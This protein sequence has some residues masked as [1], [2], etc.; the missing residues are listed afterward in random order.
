[1][2]LVTPTQSL[3]FPA[4]DYIREVII[5]TCITKHSTAMVIIDGTHIHYIDSTMAKVL[6]HILTLFVFLFCFFLLVEVALQGLKMIVEDLSVRGQ[7]VVFWRWKESAMF[8][9]L[10]FDPELS[11]YFRFEESLLQLITGTSIIILFLFYISF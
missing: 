8:T 2:L 3:V 9:V 1:M 6:K 10:G 7:E 5:Q 4:T 11:K